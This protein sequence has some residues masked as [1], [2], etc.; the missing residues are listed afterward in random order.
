MSVDMESFSSKSLAVQAQK[1]LLGK[2]ATR[3][4]AG[5]L[6]DDAASDVLDELY[7][8]RKAFSHDRKASQKAV[9]DLVKVAVKLAVLARNGQFSTDELAT[10]ERFKRKLNQA[11]LTAVSFHEVEFT[12]D[13]DVLARTLDDCREMLHRLIG[14]HLTEK[15]HARV[16]NVF[17]S[18]GD[19]EFLAALY[20]TE[21][22]FQQHLAKICQ[23]L[24]KLMEDGNI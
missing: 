19:G 9:K 16:D 3:S 6:I 17:R 24:N 12:F 4:V 1:K 2:M 8:A 7:R 23:G 21:P 18:F 20:G 10:A 13:R 5:F 14:H 15:S 22:A 11:T